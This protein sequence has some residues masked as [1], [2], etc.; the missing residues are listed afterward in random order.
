MDRQAQISILDTHVWLWLMEGDPGIGAEVIGALEHAASVGLL[1]VTSLS[2]WEIAMLE[3]AGRVRFTVPVETWL[4]EALETPG[5]NLMQIDAQVAAESV[6]LPGEFPGDPV[7][8]L[9]VAAVRTHGGTLYT[10]DPVLASYAST[11]AIRV[12]PV[13]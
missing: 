5:L 1:Y 6:R 13:G 9:L 2:L 11:G 7:D 4:E 8:A 12:Q 3:R 10:A